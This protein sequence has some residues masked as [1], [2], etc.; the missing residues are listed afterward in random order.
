MLKFHIARGSNLCPTSHGLLGRYTIL[1]VLSFNPIM[2][3]C[4]SSH[5][6]YIQSVVLIL[7]TGQFWNIP[8]TVTEGDD[9]PYVEIYSL[10]ADNTA[11]YIPAFEYSLTWDHSQKPCYYVRDSQGGPERFYNQVESVIQGY[12]SQYQTAGLLNF[13]TSFIYEMFDETVC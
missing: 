12:Q 13:E 11:A 10:G 3:Y 2:F 6:S 8:I 1:L 5:Y 4:Q 9:G 7:Y